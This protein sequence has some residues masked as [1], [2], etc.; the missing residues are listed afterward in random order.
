MQ[1]ETFHVRN[2]KCGGCVANVRT[3]L[4]KVAGVQEV[5]VE[6]EGGRVTVQGERLDRGEL[7]AALRALGYPEA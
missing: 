6:I 7:S 3:G 2:I 5:D 1:T 4:S